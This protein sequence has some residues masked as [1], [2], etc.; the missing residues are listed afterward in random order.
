MM[1]EMGSNMAVMTVT[2]HRLPSPV[3]RICNNGDKTIKKV[4]N[5]NVKR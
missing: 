3:K 5:M 1:Q 2:V 4:V